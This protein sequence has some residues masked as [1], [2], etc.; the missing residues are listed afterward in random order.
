MSTPTSLAQA[1][2]IL[3]QPLFHFHTCLITFFLT[4]QLESS[5]KYKWIT[6]LLLKTLP[7]LPM[8]LGLNPISLCWHFK[9]QLLNVFN[10]SSFAWSPS[11]ATFHNCLFLGHGFH[12]FPYPSEAMMYISLQVPSSWLYELRFLWYWLFCLLSLVPSLHG[13]DLLKLFGGL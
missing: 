1:T 7:R 12:I 3:S 13:V 10:P 11:L 4:Q 6:S 5:S 9:T 8:T 2:S